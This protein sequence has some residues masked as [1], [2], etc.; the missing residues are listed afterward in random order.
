LWVD[1]GAELLEVRELVKQQVELDHLAISMTASPSRGSSSPVR[2][3]AVE[4]V[5]CPLYQCL[6]VRETLRILPL[7]NARELLADHDIDPR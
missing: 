1:R 7:R 5:R 6:V 3:V 4:E 2:F